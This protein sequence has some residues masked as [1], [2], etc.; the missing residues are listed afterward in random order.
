MTPAEE[1]LRCRPYI[2]AALEYSE[3]T[4]EFSDIVDGIVEGRMQFWPAEKSALVTEIVIY[5]RKKVLHVFLGGGD[6]DEIK[7]MYDAVQSWGAHM[8][9]TAMTVTGRPGWVRA[10][11][12]LGFRPSHQTVIKEF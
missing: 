2:E 9:C 6:M 4:H 11:R 7:G 1:L 10:L 3:G 12:D 5:P 8:G